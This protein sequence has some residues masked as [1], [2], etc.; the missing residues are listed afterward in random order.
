MERRFSLIVFYWLLWLRVSSLVASSNWTIPP[1]LKTSKHTINLSDTIFFRGEKVLLLVFYWFL[2]LWVSPLVESSTWSICIS[3]CK[4]GLYFKFDALRCDV[5]L[6][7]DW[8]IL[9]S[10][11]ISLPIKISSNT[12]STSPSQYR[13]VNNIFMQ[14]YKLWFRKITYLYE[15]LVC[16]KRD[17][18]GLWLIFNVIVELAILVRFFY[19]GKYSS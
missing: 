2:W 4:L 15:S 9:L 3:S 12:K 17:Y 19:V 14:V 1:H 13:L 18:L 10:D 16:A 11:G 5:Y 6:L 7:V 8:K